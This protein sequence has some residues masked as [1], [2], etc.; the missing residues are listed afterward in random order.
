[1]LPLHTLSNL[2]ACQ[3]HQPPQGD[4]TLHPDGRSASLTDRHLLQLPRRE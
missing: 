2:Q 3:N 1:M 4:L